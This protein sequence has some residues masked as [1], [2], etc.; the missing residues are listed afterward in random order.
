M[1]P[2]G[3]L[4]GRGEVLLADEREAEERAGERHHRGDEEDVDEAPVNPVRTA[5]RSSAGTSRSGI[6]DRTAPASAPRGSAV[7][8]SAASARA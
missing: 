7:S 6:D 1:G 8:S 2:S 4:R 3:V 5:S